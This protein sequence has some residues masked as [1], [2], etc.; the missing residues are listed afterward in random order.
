VHNATHVASRDLPR[1]DLRLYSPCAIFPGHSH[2][3]GAGGGAHLFHQFLLGASAN[4]G[5]RAEQES[6]RVRLRPWVLLIGR[7]IGRHGGSANP[8]EA[9]LGGSAL[10]CS[11]DVRR[12]H[13]ELGATLAFASL[14]TAAC[15]LLRP[16][17]KL[18]DTKVDL[19]IWNHW[20]KPAPIQIT[21]AHAKASLRWLQRDPPEVTEARKGRKKS[22]KRHPCLGDYRASAIVV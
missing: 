19:S 8:I 13:L 18:P 10:D 12:N 5:R 6:H 22:W 17:S 2:A 7:S 15:L 14:G 11:G 16:L 4:G 21:T 3:A 9:L 1:R 20:V